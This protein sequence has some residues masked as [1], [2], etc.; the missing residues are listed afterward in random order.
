[1]SIFEMTGDN[2][3]LNIG[4]YNNDNYDNL[5]NS[6]YF[7]EDPLFSNNS[8]GVTNTGDHG[9]RDN[10][11]S[12]NY[13]FERN[14]CLNVDFSKYILNENNCEW[15]NSEIHHSLDFSR[16]NDNEQVGIL[17][18]YSVIHDLSTMSRGISSQSDSN[19]KDISSISS[20]LNTI[21]SNLQGESKTNTSITS[22]IVKEDNNATNDEKKVNIDSLKKAK[23][24]FNFNY[25]EKEIIIP[26]IKKCGDKLIRIYNILRSDLKKLMVERRSSSHLIY[27]LKSSPLEVFMENIAILVYRKRKSKPSN[28]KQK[29]ESNKQEFIRKVIKKD[30]ETVILGKKL[31]KGIKLI[32][33]IEKK[34]NQNSIL[35]KNIQQ[36]I[37]DKRL[38]EEFSSWKNKK[39]KKSLLNYTLAEL[40]VLQK[41]YGKTNDDYIEKNKGRLEKFFES[42]KEA[43]FYKNKFLNLLKNKKKIKSNNTSTKNGNT[44]LKNTSEKKIP[45]SER[46]KTKCR[47]CKNIHKLRMF[48]PTLVE[49]VKR[50]KSRDRS[51]VKIESQKFKLPEKKNKTFIF[52]DSN[53]NLTF[54]EKTQEQSNSYNNHYSNLTFNDILTIPINIVKY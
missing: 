51:E 1:M 24:T 17:G 41:N 53:S 13:Q 4:N 21:S 33:A 34:A 28:K 44:I 2:S 12:N 39:S 38:E 10:L 23:L 5:K 32:I 7:S 50:F 43:I 35:F 3:F 6:P 26:V 49:S 37:K 14:H 16:S 8:T 48:F 54:R 15:N 22:H 47:H 11:F 18:N 40:S 9:D 29:N 20:Q 19:S 27:I 25:I 31:L 46:T 42:E 30:K 36:I 45:V 52:E